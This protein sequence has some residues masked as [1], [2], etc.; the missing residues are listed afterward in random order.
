[1]DYCSEGLFNRRDIVM[2]KLLQG[3]AFATA[4]LTASAAFAATALVTTDLNLRTGPGTGYRTITSMPDGALVDV[5]GCTRGYGWCRVNYRGY[6][7]WASAGYLAQNTG[8]YEGRSY[9]GYGA[10]IGIPLIAGAVIGAAI[11]GNDHDD[12]YY[13]H[14]HYRHSRGHDRHDGDWRRHVSRD[15][16]HDWNRGGDRHFEGHRVIRNGWC[17]NGARKYHG[18]C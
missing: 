8:N 3:I 14:R 2:K 18:A 12:D 17:A 4:M 7:G 13:R 16:D 1:M 10:E 15:R 9:S 5:R 11:L 6:D